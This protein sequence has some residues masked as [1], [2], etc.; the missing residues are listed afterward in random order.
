MIIYLSL[1]DSREDH[2]KFTVLYNTYRYPMMHT[3][4]TILQ[5]HGLAEDAVHDAF[6]RVAKNFSKVG[7]V[8]SSR[9]KAF[10]IV[11]VRN[12]ALTM[13]KQRGKAVVFEEENTVN[14]IADSTSD[15]DFENFDFDRIVGIIRNLPPI[16]RDAIYLNIVEGYSVKEISDILEIGNEAVKKRLQR[17]RKKLIDRLEKEGIVN[18]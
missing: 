12:V 7:D 1:L 9:T 6:V 16:Y 11:I 14:T 18:G 17:G 10:M 5:D 3:A 15:K 4:Y 2:S 13:A 8:N